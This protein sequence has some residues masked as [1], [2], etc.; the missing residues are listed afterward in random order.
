MPY[1][2]TDLK[3][4]TGAEAV[5]GK[6]VTVNY[7]GWL[8]HA[9]QAS[10]KGAQFDTS[11]GKVAVR[12]RARAG[13]VIAGWDRGVAGMKVGGARRLVIPPSLGTARQVR[14]IPGNATLVFDVDLLAVAD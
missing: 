8:Y 1:S 4:G 13:R 6:L 5:A 14:A 10:Q 3:I 7:T 2:Q 11:V 9:S 12:L